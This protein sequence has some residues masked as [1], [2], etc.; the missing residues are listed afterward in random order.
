MNQETGWCIINNY[1]VFDNMVNELCFSKG[2]LK[3]CKLIKC[4]VSTLL[5]N[6]QGYKSLLLFFSNNV[7]KNAYKMPSFLLFTFTDKINEPKIPKVFVL[8][9]SVCFRLKAS[10]CSV[11]PKT[12]NKLV[13]G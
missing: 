12:G 8:S 7:C 13:L 4:K 6:L 2:L 9:H 1:A 5:K 10:I 3:L 11:L